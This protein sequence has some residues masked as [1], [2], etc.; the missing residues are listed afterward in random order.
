[1]AAYPPPTSNNAFNPSDFSSITATT[2]STT[3][4]GLTKS[5]ADNYYLHYS[6][7]QGQETLNGGVIISPYVTSAALAAFTTSISE[8]NT[9]GQLTISNSGSITIFENASTEGLT[10]TATEATFALP[11][12]SP[13][14]T[15]TPADNQLI[16]KSY[17]DSTYLTEVSGAYAPVNNP[18][19]G[20][21]NYAPST[22]STVY[23]PIAGMTNYAPSTGSTVYQ[24]IEGMSSYLT[25][26]SAST[27]Y[28]PATGSTVYQTQAGMTSYLTT[29]TASTTYATISSLGIYPHS[30]NITTTGNPNVIN[31]ILLGGT[32]VAGNMSFQGSISYGY[33][34]INGNHWFIAQTFT[35]GIYIPV[36]FPTTPQFGYLTLTSNI[37][38]TG[39]SYVPQTPKIFIQSGNQFYIQI[40]LSYNATPILMQFT[41]SSVFPVG[42]TGQTVTFTQV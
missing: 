35:G 28:A 33:T 11:I 26:A 10:L 3:T 4:T 38:S 24:T 14:I 32:Y 22:G 6:Q 12:I 40:P 1:M 9:S 27:T 13:A 42:T 23:Q 34:D 21:N 30:Y 37:Y 2:A 7:S 36:G 31:Y 29:A 18:D 8:D 20:Q 39:L 15:G 19:G 25:T 17:A 16:T 41:L 5:E